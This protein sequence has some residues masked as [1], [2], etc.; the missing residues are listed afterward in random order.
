[1]GFGDQQY[2]VAG[3]KYGE[4]PNAFVAS[5]ASRL[6]A[7]AQVVVP[8]DGEGRNGVWLA[9]QGHIVLALDQSEVGL[10]KARLLAA[11]RGVNIQTACVDLTTWQPQPHSADAVVLT[12]VHLPPA[13]R[14]A[15]HGKCV[16]AL[17][18]GGLLIL[19]AFAPAQLPLA[20]GGPKQLDMLFSLDMLRADFVPA[21]KELVG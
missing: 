16:E 14:A 17:K 8:A 3:Y 6:P 10:G 5:Q 15:V 4:Q 12:F 1:M 9:Q 13:A 11:K 2:S 20:S 18:P 7:Y 21:L 19:E